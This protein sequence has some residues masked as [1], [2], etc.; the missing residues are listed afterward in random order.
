[1]AYTQPY[2]SEFIDCK[3]IAEYEES[4]GQAELIGICDERQRIYLA[5][6]YQ[7]TTQEIIDEAQRQAQDDLE[8]TIYENS[9]QAEADYL[10]EEE[11]RRN[12]C[13]NQ[14]LSY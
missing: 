2:Q 14:G 1:M 11:E 12:I 3:M 6:E 7:T 10:I 9:E 8:Q 13:L 4:C 5:G